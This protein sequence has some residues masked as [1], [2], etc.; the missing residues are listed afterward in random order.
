MKLLS[1]I[2][3]LAT[4]VSVSAQ[5]SYSVKSLKK[6]KPEDTTYVYELPFR[7]GDKHY[8]IQGYNTIFSHKGECAL[9]FT[10]KKGTVVCA[11]RDGIVT[12]IKENGEK[13]GMTYAFAGEGNYIEIRHSDGA[14]AGYWHLQKNGATVNVGDTVKTGQPIGLSGHTGWSAMPHLHFYVYGYDKKGNYVSYPTRFRTAKGIIYLKPTRR[15]R[16]TE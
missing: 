16:R 2:L 11:A 1:L 8:L 7:T 12:E 5:S 4:G 13:H 10:M 6:E 14:Y 15:Y 3:F 9:D